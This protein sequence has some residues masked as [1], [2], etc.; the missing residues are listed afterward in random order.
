MT[1]DHQNNNDI[2]EDENFTDLL[3][4]SYVDNDFLDPGQIIEAEIVKITDEWIFLNLG[5]KS[6]GHLEAKELT[7]ENGSL[8]VKE[9]DTI[10]AYFMSSQNGEMLFTT[11]IS[12]DHAGHAV[13]ENAYENKIPVEG[14]VEKEIKGGYEIK[15]GNLQAFCPY[16]QMGLTQ[17][18]N[19]EKNIGQHLSFIISE[20]SEKG[21]NIV[22]SNRAIL[23][24]ERKAQVEALKESLQEDMKVKGS[25]KSIQDFGA[26]VDIGGVQALLPISEI[27]RSRVNDIQQF[28]KIDQEIETAIIK[29]D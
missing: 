9:G 24:E 26:F 12:G 18:D 22:L 17:N 27:S 4:D 23:E 19:P 15:I 6:E 21:R 5:R 14:F 28:I 29:L 13:L 25:V 20:F 2:N 3:E 8:T 16:S 10:K 1:Q 7:D 11:K